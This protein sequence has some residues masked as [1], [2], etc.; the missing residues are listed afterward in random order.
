MYDRILVPVDARIDDNGALARAFEFARR[1][2]A[3]IHL[4]HV[5]DIG[6]ESRGIPE[7]D[8][9]TLEGS[10]E[11][12]GR[13][14]TERIAEQAHERGLETVQGLR[15]G[16][17]HRS[18]VDYADEH[19]IDLIV[20]G[21]RARSGSDQVRLGSTTERVVLNAQAP[22]LAV[23]RPDD[24]ELTDEEITYDTIVI[25]TDG[26]DTA[27]R[28]TERALSVAAQYDATVE[29]MYVIDTTT[30][31]LADV[32][33]SIVGLLKEGG[34][35]AVEAIEHDGRERGVTVRTTVRRGVPEKEILT[36]ADEIGGDLLVMGISGRGGAG[37]HYL[38]STTARVLRR[39]SR[40]I[41]TVR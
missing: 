41:L 33:R 11:S 28:V 19:E 31:D 15:Q 1:F 26:S 3:T 17:A 32:P 10:L 38:G 36:Y 18:L 22:V 34:N 12:V 6:G 16:L 24:N 35:R 29:A 8:R 13:K 14:A 20:M 30:Y 9:S 4:V 21:T 5:V 37:D 40:P 25:A 27:D 7:E 23:P 39:S 2:D